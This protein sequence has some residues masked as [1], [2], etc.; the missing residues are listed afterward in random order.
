MAAVDIFTSGDMVLVFERRGHDHQDEKK[1]K[2]EYA[3]KP[4][5]KDKTDK[6]AKLARTNALFGPRTRST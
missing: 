6:E 1:D 4:D 5:S 3:K 2:A